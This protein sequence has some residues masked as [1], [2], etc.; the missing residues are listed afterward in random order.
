M[1][2]AYRHLAFTLLGALPLVSA[3]SRDWPQSARCSTSVHGITLAFGFTLIGVAQDYPIHLFSH[4]ARPD[5]AGPARAGVAAAR[6]RRGSTCIA[7]LAFL[8]SGVTDSRSSR[9]SRRRPRR[10][11]RSPRVRVAA[12]VPAPRAI[13]P[14]RRCWRARGHSSRAAAIPCACLRAARGAAVAILVGDRRVLAERSVEAHTRAD[15]LLAR[16]A[17]LRREMATPDVRYLMVARRATARAVLRS[18]APAPGLPTSVR[19]ARSAAT[20]TPRVICRARRRNARARQL[21]EARRARM[22]RCRRRAMPFK[23]DA[24]EPLRRGR[25]AGQDRCLR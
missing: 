25:G 17:E 12:V 16:D 19:T 21:P 15:A 14:I 10:R 4:R 9:A 13:R 18:R 8:A 20:T 23:D 22:L 6:H 5:A 1:W 7:Y 2:F 11:R 24:F 3:R